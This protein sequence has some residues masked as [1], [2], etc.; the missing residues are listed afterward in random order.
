MMPGGPAGGDDGDDLIDVMETDYFA[1]SADP[2]EETISIAFFERN[3]I[4]EF[5][6]EELIDFAEVVE[7]SR[8][9]IEDRTR[10]K[11]DGRR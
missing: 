9:F 10:Q 6:Y 1:V 5:T 7:R 2:T 3:L 11:G 4:M 8:A